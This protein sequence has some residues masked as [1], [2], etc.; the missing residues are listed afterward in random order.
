MSKLPS[1]DRPRLADEICDFLRDQIYAGRFSPGT[2]LRQEQLAEELQVSRTPLREALRVLQS[3]GLLLERRGN[4]VEV[5]SADKDRFLDALLLRELVD[6]AA[7][8]LCAE[9][10]LPPRKRAAFDRAITA[11]QGAL[12]PWDR[13]GFARGDADLHAAILQLSGNFYLDQQIKI[14]RLTI[15]V[16]QMSTNFGPDEAAA[17]IKEHRAIVK[18]IASGD[19]DKAEQLSRSHIHRVIGELRSAPVSA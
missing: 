12:K 14:V 18:A 1:A 11:Q 9:K 13:T 8:R 5:I 10:D 15:Q 16:F 2:Q 17:K 6:G 4:R 19:G 3:E 7:A